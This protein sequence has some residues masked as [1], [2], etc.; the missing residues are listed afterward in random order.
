MTFCQP[1]FADSSPENIRPGID[2]PPISP[3]ASADEVVLIPT[4]VAW[5]TR[6]TAIAWKVNSARQTRKVIPMNG[7]VFTIL[8]VVHELEMGDDFCSPF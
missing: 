4:S 3:R 5:G 6:W 8:P 1:V 7:M 2:I